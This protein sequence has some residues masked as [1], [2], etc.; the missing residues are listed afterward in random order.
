MSASPLFNQQDVLE[1]ELEG[2]FTTLVANIP[3]REQHDMTLR[4]D[5]FE[6][7]VRVRVRG[8]SRTRECEFPPLRLHFDKN[9]VKGTVFEG[10]HK[11]KLAT[12]CRDR[13]SAE[14]NLLDE[15]AAYRAFEAV[16]GAAFRTRLV[17]IRYIDAA[18]KSKRAVTVRYAFLIES[19]GELA[20]R[21]NGTPLEV[22]GVRRSEINEAQAA[23]V[24]MF[25]YMI[26]NTDWSLVR[27]E[28]DEECCHNLDLVE[29]DGS[30]YLI[31]YD[32]DL[33][34]V[35]NAPYARPDPS[36]GL[37]SVRQRRYRGYCLPEPAHRRAIRHFVDRRRTIL[38]SAG[39]V[40]AAD[41]DVARIV[42]YLDDFFDDTGKPDRL[43]ARFER[44]CL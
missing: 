21:I 13:A 36:L 10:Q 35:V 2:P 31:P 44:Y 9:D 28:E 3:D 39:S 14:I 22:E 26:G 23:L 4:L 29:V 41:S 7:P 20:G 33:A 24:Y 27:N 5:G 19:I 40:P 38:A 18:H 42:N 17:R 30:T 32:F 6:L 16:S 34:G 12:H 1:M 15:L 11:L 8:K 25:Q 43:L 37:R